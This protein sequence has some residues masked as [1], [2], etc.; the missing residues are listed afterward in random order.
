MRSVRN[1]RPAAP[2]CHYA[3]ATA[4]ST[5]SLGRRRETPSGAS[6]PQP[7]AA[8]KERTRTMSRIY[9]THSLGRPEGHTCFA[10]C[11]CYNAFEEVKTVKF[12]ERDFPGYPPNGDWSNPVPASWHIATVEDV[13][14][15]MDLGGHKARGESNRRGRHPRRRRLKKVR[16]SGGPRCTHGH[17]GDS[18]PARR[19]DAAPR[20]AGHESGPHAL[21]HGPAAHRGGARAA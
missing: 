8:A 17:E 5:A 12:P 21:C 19:R 7:R 13:P 6:A 4:Y 1:N 2:V 9:G 18:I 16:H 3:R 15:V 20:H 10:V 11:A 14:W